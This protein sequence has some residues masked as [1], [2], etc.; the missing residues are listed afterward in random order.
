M[1]QIAQLG[2]E[3][4]KLQSRLGL[5]NPRNLNPGMT[6]EEL[7]TCPI[8]NGVSPASEL[9][10]FFGWRNGA[11]SGG[12]PMRKLWFIPGHYLVSADDSLLSNRYLTK[13]IVDWSPTW[14]PLMFDG[15]VVL[16]F[17]DVMKITEGRSPVFVSDPESPP[18]VCQIY[19]SVELMFRAV[20]E[21][22]HRRAYFV[23]PEG[24]L[25]SN[26]EHV[27]GISRRLNPESNH[28]QRTD[29]Y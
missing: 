5:E 8:L 3:I 26:A 14:F 1:N 17:F 12:V 16:H 2:S 25:D 18:E 10:E 20:L 22:Y 21:C 19:D 4:L 15:S 11:I 28:W 29:L 13:Q 9:H 6:P 27:S 7:A 23:G 24:F